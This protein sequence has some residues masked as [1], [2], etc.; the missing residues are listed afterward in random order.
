M[1]LNLFIIIISIILSFQLINDNNINN[2]NQFDDII[3][4][5]GSIG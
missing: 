2:I 5:S 3:E 4:N 1:K